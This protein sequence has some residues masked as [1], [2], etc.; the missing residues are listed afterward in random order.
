[1]HSERRGAAILLTVLAVTLFAMLDTSVRHATL[2]M[3]LSIVLLAR[4]ALQ[5]L[6]MGVWL[7]ARSWRRFR[8]RNPRFQL[9]RGLL[10]ISTSAIGG[11]G[12]RFIPVAEFTAIILLSPVMVTLASVWLF[13]DHVSLVHW[14]MI[15]GAFGGAL[16]IIRPGGGNLGLY[17]LLPLAAAVVYTAFQLITR[18]MAAGD[19]P[20]T[21]HFYT[22]LIGTVATLPVAAWA[23]TAMPNAAAV[24]A[25]SETFWLLLG[26][27]VLGSVG[28]LF[29]VLS[30]GM[31]PAPVLMPFVYVQI[32][33]ATAIGWIVFGD[34]PDGWST[35][36]MAIVAACGA[37]IAW[38]NAGPVRRADALADER[39]TSA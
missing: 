12:L 8:T 10:L 13:K 1:M 17:A 9:L 20:Y 7:G 23:I 2:L 4:Y 32:A 3:P 11:Y 26:I 15:V 29:L 5:S 28:H 27:G 36:G 39:A 25:T 19:D 34:A 31:A 16:V 18:R 35:A 6:S 33:A 37:T 38:L 30:F 24:L 14:A 22:G 21:T